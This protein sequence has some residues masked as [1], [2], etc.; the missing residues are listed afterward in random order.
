M[1]IHRLGWMWLLGG[2]LL[3]AIAGQ[4][5]PAQ[6]QPGSTVPTAQTHRPA[7]AHQ[8]VLDR[9][10]RA[11]AAAECYEIVA[12][13][14]NQVK[15]QPKGGA[16]IAASVLGPEKD[17]V[18]VAYSAPNHLRV[19]QMAGHKIDVFHDA[20]HS[21]SM[22][23]GAGFTPGNSAANRAKGLTQAGMVD[24]TT[25]GNDISR[26]TTLAREDVA[27]D[28]G[29]VS[30]SVIQATYIPR[31]NGAWHDLNKPAFWVEKRTFWV[32]VSRYVVLR[33][34]DLVHGVGSIEGAEF[35]HTIAVRKMAWN[36]RPPD[37]AFDVPPVSGTLRPD[38]TVTPG[39]NGVVPA[40]PI[41]DGCRDAT[42]PLAQ[43]ACKNAAHTC[44]DLP[45]TPEA[46]IAQLGGDVQLTFTI[47][48]EGRPEDIRVTH[49]VGL[50]LDEELV[51]CVSRWRWRPAELD[52]K[53]FIVHSGLSAPVG[54]RT[55]SDWQ[56]THVEFH[57][58]SGAS[59]PVFRRADFPERG[60]V[61]GFALFHI[62]L[63]IGRDGVPRDIQVVPGI[64]KKLD[65]EAIGLVSHFRFRPGKDD[66]VPVDVPASF[67]LALGRDT[68][69]HRFN[70]GVAS[71]K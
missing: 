42:D 61:V 14:S 46:Q 5:R 59:R 63:T 37:S 68:R 15:R 49:S 31:P 57:P 36:Q 17:T 13:V 48:S 71:Q 3:P 7:R 45:V 27:A 20:E 65:K 12:T 2:S 1:R 55:R 25:I 21:F 44:R 35:E 10:I 62:H 19:E 67:D 26:T 60:Q 43:L 4:E 22:R 51:A 33:E 69:P 8:A 11:Y 32:D 34:V 53:P 56:L 54:A 29:S 9:V 58:G 16:V 50:G 70:P 64:D 40:V 30:C 28:G 41:V 39:P 66:G 52:G 18:S 38:G 47:N 24:Y 6:T 23:S